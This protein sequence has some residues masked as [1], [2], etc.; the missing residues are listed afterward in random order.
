M[1][2]M[3][4]TK[5]SRKEADKLKKDFVK[6]FEK[7]HICTYKYVHG[8]FLDMIEMREYRLR[9]YLG[10]IVVVQDEDDTAN[11]VIRV[12]WSLCSKKDNFNKYV[13]KYEAIQRL[14]KNPNEIF[15]EKDRIP[16]RFKTKLIVTARKAMSEAMM[17]KVDFDDLQS[18]YLVYNQSEKNLG[19]AI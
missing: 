3:D 1:E 12:S 15:P 13:G 6:Y 9:E 18:V 17:K 16:E 11:D 2:E 7:N 8:S 4:I 19:S 10:L 5:L 14:L